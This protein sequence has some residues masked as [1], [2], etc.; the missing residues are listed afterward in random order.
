MSI[1]QALSGYSPSQLSLPKG[2]INV[3][4]TND[5]MSERKEWNR[6]LKP[7]LKQA[8]NRIQQN[9]NKLRSERKFEIGDLVY[10]KLQPYKQS[11]VALRK[12]LK[13]VSKFYG[14]YKIL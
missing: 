2:A 7:N 13:L 1:F 8:Q 10:L 3:A 11:S 6:M 4:S 9:A 12:N 5:W 14:P